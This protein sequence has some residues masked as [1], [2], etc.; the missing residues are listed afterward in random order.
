MHIEQKV[1]TMEMS[2]RSQHGSHVR[3]RNVSLLL[4][5]S[6]RKLVDAADNTSSGREL[7]QSTLGENSQLIR[8][9]DG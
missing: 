8:K 1:V 3:D 2:R 9:S 6:Q 4:D 7:E 5:H